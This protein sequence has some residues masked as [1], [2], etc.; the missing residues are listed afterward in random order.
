MA[1]TRS[2]VQ[3]P[4][5]RPVQITVRPITLALVTLLTVIALVA[6]TLAA[7]GGSEDGQA[8]YTKSVRVAPSSG[9]MPPSPAERHRKPGLLGPG[10]HP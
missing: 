1:S 4:L 2:D 5:A 10:M 3:H 9:P 7:S 8:G 6:I